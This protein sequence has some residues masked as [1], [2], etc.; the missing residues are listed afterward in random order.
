[1]S[2]AAV[3]ILGHLY[4]DDFIRA[5]HNV[6]VRVEDTLAVNRLELANSLL[7]KSNDTPVES[8]GAR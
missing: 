3:V 6:V 1:M 8:L 5:E 7:R 4:A 2:A